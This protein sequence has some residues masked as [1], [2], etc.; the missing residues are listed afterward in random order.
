[1]LRMQTDQANAAGPIH[2][3]LVDSKDPMESSDGIFRRFASVIS[4]HVYLVINFCRVLS[5]SECKSRDWKKLAVVFY[6]LDGSRAPV[7]IT[8]CGSV[9]YQCYLEIAH[10]WRT[11]SYAPQ[12]VPL[13]GGTYMDIQ[14]PLPMAVW[15]CQN[16]EVYESSIS[17]FFNKA[18]VI[19][20]AVDVAAH[21]T[22]EQLDA[23]FARLD[24]HLK[25]WKD[26][27]TRVVV[28]GGISAS[29]RHSGALPDQSG[30]QCECAKRGLKYLPTDAIDYASCKLLLDVVI[31]EAFQ[32]LLDK[33]AL[34]K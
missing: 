14:T 16:L 28:V 21:L 7:N 13:V 33:I 8:M 32:A 5:V 24:K 6:S 26:R 12:N 20:W 17:V 30:V 4:F 27:K 11:G 3:V 22:Q 10:V 15:I 29:Q 2:L 31:E 19:V 9:D 23:Q 25:G 18:Q 1:M 34:P